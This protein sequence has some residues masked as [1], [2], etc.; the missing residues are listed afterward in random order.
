[1][2]ILFTFNYM[3]RLLLFFCYLLLLAVLG[4]ATFTE[5]A[6]G[7]AFA[8][9]HIYGSV[10]FAALWM[11]LALTGI[12]WFLR[13]RVHRLP[14]VLLHI[15]FLFILSG[16][17]LT[18][19]TAR[20]GVIHLRTGQPVSQFVLT[21]S[22]RQEKAGLPFMV[23]LKR[24]SMQR[25]TGTR[26]ASD[27]STSFAI[28][29]GE[30]YVMGEVSMNQVFSY[31][32]IRLSQLSYD[33]DLK[34]S[35]LTVNDDPW[36]IALSYTG[37]LLLA[38]S[39][40]WSLCS[41]DS[42]FRQLLR[43]PSASRLCFLLFLLP[44]ATSL[45]ATDGSVKAH[46]V[47][48]TVAKAFGQLYMDYDGRISQ[49]HTFANDFLRSIHGRTRY[50]G[51][52]ADQ[53]LLGWMF[54]PDEWNAEPLVRVKDAQLREQFLVEDYAAVRTFFLGGAY[55]LGDYLAAYAQGARHGVNRSA[56]ELDSRLQLV[57]SLRD[58]V[59][60][61][62]FPLKDGTETLW[63]S[64]ADRLPATVGQGDRL[65]ARHWLSLL[66]EQIRSNDTAGAL[67]LIGKL[68]E[69]Q[70]KQAAQCL[71][72]H[73]ASMAERVW[74]DTPFSKCLFMFNLTVGLL[75]F[76]VS[77]RQLSCR[78]AGSQLYGL[79][80][81]FRRLWLLAAVLS[82][83]TMVAVFV[84]RWCAGGHVPMTGGYDTMVLMAFF[85]LLFACMATSRFPVSLPFG[86]LVS[87][88][89]LLVAYL[90]ESDTR[91][92]SMPPVLSSPLLSIHVS[93]VMMAYAL[94]AL[95]FLCGLSAV[96]V[97]CFSSGA[98]I[99]SEQVIQS[100]HHLSRLLLHPALALL[101]TGIFI[102]A[103]WANDSWGRY[104]NWDPKETWALITLLCYAIPLH[105][106]TVPALQ[107]P[108]AYHSFMLLAFLSLLMTYFGVGWFLGGMHSY[109]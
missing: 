44:V 34:G 40:L 100:L 70:H 60:L 45:S 96:G 79:S 57:M 101:A 18:W 73:T 91:I 103:V 13:S 78:H 46:L 58:A 71:P 108:M 36:G 41:P 106:H 104:W 65:L 49:I 38:L 107:R 25:H 1:M 30:R 28:H 42:T 31:R 95:T 97:R 15:S 93:V 85:S 92:T 89:F 88:C 72:D 86:F 59:P 53:V 64:P 66:G 68:A 6:C 74:Q 35:Y 81:P 55:Q 26:T 21:N 87:G 67:R 33:S 19:L 37:Y 50:G 20:R 94:F 17:L 75:L 12:L 39:F 51:C 102:G 32:G 3:L 83:L 4:A 23:E 27:Y 10:W 22:L 29:D 82:L 90:S 109:S 80:F 56:V 14:V 84:L 105:V 16:A 48:A 54:Y 8:F 76:A 63:Y 11:M 5:R 7:T 69:Y 24:F 52:S 2:F 62:L 47:D 9:N 43:A 61:K 98:D 99:F 77:I